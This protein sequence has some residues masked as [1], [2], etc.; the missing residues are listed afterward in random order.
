MPLIDGKY[1]IISQ[2]IDRDN[3]SY[4]KAS[5]PDGST[6]RVAWYKLSSL[7]D[8]QQF[9]QFRKLLRVLK[10]EKLAA[11]YDIVSRPGAHYVVWQDSQNLSKATK[12]NTIDR[13]LLDY[14]Y[15]SQMADIRN[16]NSKA[17]VFDLKFSR[18][19]ILVSKDP[20]E[21]K[22]KKIKQSVKPQLLVFAAL[23][24]LV[25]IVILLFLS[26]QQLTNDDVVVLDNLI[27]KNINDAGKYLYAK[28]LNVGSSPSPSDRPF[29]EV[30]SMDPPAG[31]TIRPYYRTVHLVYSSPIGNINSVKVI[32]LVNREYS[33]NIANLLEKNSLHL[34][35]V[36]YIK[37]NKTPKTILGQS[38]AAG[39]LV[40]K[41]ES[42]D[43]VVSESKP[44]QS[45][46]PELKG[47]TLEDARFFVGLS[48][49]KVQE[50]FEKSESPKNTVIGQSVEAFAAV[51][52]NDANIK[53]F[54]SSGPSGNAD[55]AIVNNPNLVGL[56]L[57]EAQKIAPDYQF[58]INEISSENLDNVI[59]SQQPSVGEINTGK[60]IKLTLNNYIPPIDIP[61][62]NIETHIFNNRTRNLDYSWAVEPNLSVS[63]YKVYAILSNGQTTLV[64][65]GHIKGGEIVSGIWQTKEPGPVRFKLYL[66]GFQYSIDIIRN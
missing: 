6:V 44:G 1:E 31:E 39:S 26:I 35:K 5:A 7:E 9:E 20:V 16:V 65:E 28:H 56:S 50:V 33:A 25:S 45:F 14:G 29:G 38:K 59:V 15:K 18:E 47:M 51:N 32:N 62:P 57:T 12:H 60:V 42:I 17:Q 2:L 49:L 27:G 3:E 53:I 41:G 13:Y 23:A 46:L 22:P 24:M 58:E 63:S 34:G 10:R 37:S 43:L 30:L 52:L 66:N 36:F 64:Q 55:S 11:V 54:I 21:F 61:Q 4:F 8:E 48:G 40:A 19:S